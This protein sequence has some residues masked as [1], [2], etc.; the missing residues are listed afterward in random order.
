VRFTTA[1]LAAHLGG[2]VVGPDVAVE[3][4]SIDTRTAESGQLYIPIVA[5]RDGH[6]FIPAAIAAGCPAYLTS[7]G[8]VALGAAAAGDVA[9]GAATAVVV[10][11]TAAALMSLGE[12]ARGRISGEV[13]GITGSVGKTT[14]KDILARCLASTFTTAAS[15]RSFNNEL[16][17]PLTLLNVPEDVQRVVLE[18]GARGF[19]HIRRLL[20]VA[21]PEVGIV[22]SVAV[23]HIEYFGDLDGVARAK[24]ELV[25]GLPSSGVA[26]LNL[27]DARVARMADSSPC[28]VLGYSVHGDEA[29]TEAQ[30]RAEIV[31]IDAELRPRFR[32]VTPWG[33]AEVHLSLHGVQQVGNALAASSAALWCGVP[34]ETVVASLA[35]VSA[36]PLRMEVRHPPGGPTLLVD[37]YNA[38]PASTEA[39]LQSLAVLPAASRLALL[40]V[41][42][43]LGTD[44]ASEHHR[45]ASVAASLGIEVVGYETDLYG[46]R[47]VRGLDEAVELLRSA[48]H[49][50][51][52]LVKGSR[53]ARLEE[54][55]GAFDGQS[56][57]PTPGPAAST[58]T[59]EESSP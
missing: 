3:G 39:A 9:V 36:S 47:S 18:M 4:A 26:V 14:T 46:S 8:P 57:S 55:V 10:D 54:V 45:I 12:F 1:G 48:G 24:G 42:A 56:P 19:G 49:T 31:T 41:M 16:G 15:E 27:D 44:T 43:E 50:G 13:I 29:H 32:L 25:E 28:P 53:V 20:G 33:S 23:A 38:N 37:C 35:D 7:R 22:T 51:A 30:V 58:S 5:D 40:G 11:D 59:R 52:V 34:L 21:R 17:L 2:T 6:D